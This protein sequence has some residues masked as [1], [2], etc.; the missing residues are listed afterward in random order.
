MELREKANGLS[1]D[2]RL[3]AYRM[4]LEHR[5]V[6]ENQSMAIAAI[7]QKIGCGRDKVTSSEW[8]RIAGTDFAGIAQNADE[9]P[10]TFSVVL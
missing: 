9:H 7:G 1:P 4:A 5:R 10:V 8:A 6:N 2:V 3:P